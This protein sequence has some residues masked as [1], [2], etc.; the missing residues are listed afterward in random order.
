MR[1][2]YP[3]IQHSDG[4]KPPQTRLPTPRG[5]CP[6][7]GRLHGFR[8]GRRS[9]RARRRTA[10]IHRTPGMQGCGDAMPDIRTDG[11]RIADRHPRRRNIRPALSG[12]CNRPFRRPK[13]RRTETTAHQGRVAKGPSLG[14]RFEANDLPTP[15]SIHRPAPPKRNVLPESIFELRIES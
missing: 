1:E 8:H 6:K 12:A 14:L 10:E 3:R 2:P 13:S 4:T 7:T 9:R 5:L 15:H 11:R